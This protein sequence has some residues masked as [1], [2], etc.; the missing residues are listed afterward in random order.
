[1]SP[2]LG[3]A[4]LTAMFSAAATGGAAT[5]RLVEGELVRV[6]LGKRLLVVRPSSGGPL[7]V[8][9]KVDSATAI[10]ASG[11]SL[12]LDELKT[13]ERIVVACQGE[14]ALSCRARRVRAGPSRHAVPPSP[15]RGRRGLG[16]LSGG[17][18]ATKSLTAS[19]RAISRSTP[20]A[21]SGRQ[22]LQVSAGGWR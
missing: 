17:R 22:R 8:D 11:R 18:Q 4:F 13:G 20:I 3:R 19:S 5:D 15:P 6:D 21:G 16:S 10:S 12:P 7:E 9:V 14:D 1:M 2:A